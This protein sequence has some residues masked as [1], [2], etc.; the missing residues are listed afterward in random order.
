MLAW[1]IGVSALAGSV[2]LYGNYRLFFSNDRSYLGPM[3][4]ATLAMLSSYTYYNKNKI[5]SK[6]TQ[7]ATKR[8]ILRLGGSLDDLV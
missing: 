2:I 6:Q 7:E 3:A 8:E 5:L 1:N 4:I